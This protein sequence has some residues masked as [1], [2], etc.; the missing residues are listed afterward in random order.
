V[1]S[2]VVPSPCRRDIHPAAEHEAADDTPGVGWPRQDD[3]LHRVEFAG[4]PG[5]PVAPDATRLE[6]VVDALV[7][8]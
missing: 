1:G 6:Q 3:R 4:C 8:I 2:D 7:R 5:N